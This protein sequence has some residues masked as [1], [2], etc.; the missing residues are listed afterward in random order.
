MNSLYNNDHTGPAN[1]KDSS[2]NAFKNVTEAQNNKNN[3]PLTT[4]RK[5]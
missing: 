4:G 5:A 1:R 3:Y 2:S